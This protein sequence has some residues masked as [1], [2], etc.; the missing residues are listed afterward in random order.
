MNEKTVKITK[1]ASSYNVQVLDSFYPKLQLEDTESAIKNKFKRLLFE[2]R[3]FT[4]VTTLVFV[5]KKIEDEDKTKFDTFYSH[6]KAETI[7]KESD[8][9]DN[10][11][12]S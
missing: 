6:S 10:V 5:L 2:L 3:G 1:R 9:D 4:F 8:I 11:F 12:K 7:I